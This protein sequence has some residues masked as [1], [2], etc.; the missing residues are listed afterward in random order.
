MDG[1]FTV[2]VCTAH[3]G[4]RVGR[5]GPGEGLERPRWWPVTWQLSGLTQPLI[6][7]ETSASSA[8]L[9]A[10]DEW[11]APAATGEG[12]AQLGAAGVPH[13]VVQRGVEPTCLS[14]H[15]AHRAPTS[16]KPSISI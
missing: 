12:Q 6:G 9:A 7:N 4:E 3:V 11:A 2:V 14:S 13:P 10:A 1:M 16:S 8:Y 5:G 15:A